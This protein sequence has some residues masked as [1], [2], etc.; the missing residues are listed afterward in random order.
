MFR[1]VNEELKT[2][3]EKIPATNFDWKEQITRK[4]SYSRGAYPE[5]L[6]NRNFP[7]TTVM[8]KLFQV[9]ITEIYTF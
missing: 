9:I 5:H 6:L 2:I 3:S 4:T 8:N 1:G 7:K